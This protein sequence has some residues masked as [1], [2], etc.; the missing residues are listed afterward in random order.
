MCLKHQASAEEHQKAQAARI[1]CERA[2]AAN[3][4]VHSYASPRKA[5]A[6]TRDHPAE[7]SGG[8][9]TRVTSPILGTPQKE[10]VS[11]QV[12]DK[13]GNVV[14]GGTYDVCV[15]VFLRVCVG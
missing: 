2:L 14:V 8:G 4:D 12:Q 10:I 6:G 1:E 13:I 3:G 9:G 11:S 7:G 5:A 15:C